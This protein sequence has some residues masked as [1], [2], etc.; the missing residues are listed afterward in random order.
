MRIYQPTEGEYGSYRKECSNGLELYDP[1]N[2]SYPY[3]PAEL[4]SAFLE[5]THCFP[6]FQ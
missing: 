3:L 2:P 6:D 4:A 1:E 5:D